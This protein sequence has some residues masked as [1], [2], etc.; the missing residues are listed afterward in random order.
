MSFSLI[1]DPVWA[2]ISKHDSC[3]KCHLQIS[4]Q[5]YSL[6]IYQWWTRGSFK[7]EILIF[8]RF[9]LSSFLYNKSVSRVTCFFRQIK[10]AAIQKF[11]T[12]AFDNLQICILG[13]YPPIL[14][15]KSLKIETLILSILFL[16]SFLYQE[17]CMEKH[18]FFRQ[19]QFAGTQNAR[20]SSI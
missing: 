9:S 8:S 11:Q 16:S 19:I 12:Q 14:E 20:D 3:S 15:D 2:K 7:I 6:S 10:V 13:Y 4:K 1:S 18:V 5:I 17:M